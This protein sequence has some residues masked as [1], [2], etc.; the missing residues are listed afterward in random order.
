MK[1]W[2]DEISLL[3]LNGVQTFHKL[4][5]TSSLVSLNVHGAHPA[6]SKSR[7]Y[8]VALSYTNMTLAT[9]T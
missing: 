3:R 6:G 8:S 1:F 7:D 4:V 9:S 5:K 2:F